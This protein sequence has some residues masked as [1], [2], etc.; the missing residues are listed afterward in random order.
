MKS[1]RITH[2]YL[3]L[4]WSNGNQPAYTAEVE[5]KLSEWAPTKYTLS[6]LNDLLTQATLVA[7]QRNIGLQAIGMSKELSLIHI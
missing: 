7:A 2:A 6:D 4:N 1:L 5:E 3:V